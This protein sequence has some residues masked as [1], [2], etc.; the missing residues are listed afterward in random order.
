MTHDVPATLLS[1]EDPA[2]FAVENEAAS[3]DFVLVCDHAG[4]RIPRRLGRL[5]LSERELETHIAWDIGVAD[6][7]RLLATRLDALLITQSYSR[8][9]VDA[10][11]P[12][13]SPESIVT[14]SEA[15]PVPGN[16][17]L[18]DAQREQ[19][20]REIFHPYHDRIRV[21]LDRRER[22]GRAAILVA[23]HSFTPVF[24]DRARDWQAG[25]L[26]NRE[27][28]FARLVL[29]ELRRDPHLIVGEN[30]PYAA[31]DATD[32]TIVVHGEQR[33]LD[34]VEIELR[35][36]LLVEA[37]ARREWAERVAHALEAARSSLLDARATSAIVGDAQ[38][39][40]RTLLP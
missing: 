7:A 2:P 29:A 39:L 14:L 26:Y 20:A 1:D 34:Q 37:D 27:P 18:A 30:E 35:Q 28:R 38:A 4:N 9:V 13:E 17:G 31:S 5:G 3:S 24:R 40:P 10:N 11:R 21:E 16:E 32:Y 15:T 6:T 23:L 8:L 33:G 12:L 36:D 19:R 22:E 25:V